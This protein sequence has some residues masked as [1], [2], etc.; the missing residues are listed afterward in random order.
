M[1]FAV[2]ILP[3]TADSKY[4]LKI[5]TIQLLRAFIGRTENTVY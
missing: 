4:D 5:H 3:E 2:R 1:T